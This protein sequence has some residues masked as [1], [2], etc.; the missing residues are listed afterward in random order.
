MR[1]HL[2]LAVLAAAALGVA[3][4]GTAAADDATDKIKDIKGCMA[5][6]KTK[7]A[8]DDL[9]ARLKGASPDWDD[10]QKE[11]KQW[12]GVAETLG[13]QTPPRGSAESWKKQTDKYL[14]NVKAV[15]EAA[16]K[17]DAPAATKAIATIGMCCAGCHGQHRP[18]KQ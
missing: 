14:E 9:P 16:Q 13:K 10:I 1:L 15:D 12:V 8:R 17:K 2:K 3:Y 7:V 18:K 11:T 5:F 6:T 4:L